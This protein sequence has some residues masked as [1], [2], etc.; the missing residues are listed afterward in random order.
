MQNPHVKP[1]FLLRPE[2]QFEVGGGSCEYLEP[3]VIPLMEYML[4]G[5]TQKWNKLR[6]P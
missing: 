3:K 4:F 1:V 6:V 5:F 2:E